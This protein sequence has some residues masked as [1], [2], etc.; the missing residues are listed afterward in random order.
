MPGTSPV[1]AWTL[2]LSTGDDAQTLE[3]WTGNVDQDAAVAQRI[4]DCFAPKPV[5]PATMGVIVDPG[6][7]VT[8][9]GGAQIITEKTGQVLTIAAA[10]SAPNDRIDLIVV[11]CVTGVASVVAGTPATSPAAPALPA[12]KMQIAQ[13]SVPNGTSAISNANITDLRV[14]W[15][16]PPFTTSFTSTAGAIPA[17]NSSTSYAHGL[18]AVP[19]DAFVLL[20]CITADQGW[21]VGQQVKVPGGAGT[22]SSSGFAL[23]W[24]ATNVDLFMS[25]GGIYLPMPASAGAAG[26]ITR[27]NWTLQIKT[28]L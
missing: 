22:N 28:W 12:G 1:G 6:F 8:Q 10:P 3:A 26:A 20:T 27:A 25:S 4:V 19:W 21:T 17:A 13:V 7:V 15:V 16:I 14:L 23:S 2:P 24:D 18:G 11:D 5:D 9:R